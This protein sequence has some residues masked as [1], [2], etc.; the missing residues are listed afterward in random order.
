MTYYEILKNAEYGISAK[1]NKEE[2]INERTKKELGRENSISLFHLKQYEK[3]FSEI[4]N[5]IFLEEQKQ[6]EC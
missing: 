5:L 4:S 2:E 1:M 3:D 6:A